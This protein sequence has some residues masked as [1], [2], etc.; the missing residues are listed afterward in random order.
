MQQHHCLY[1]GITYLMAQ[2][3][4]F[5]PAHIVRVC[6]RVCTQFKNISDVR[7]LFCLRS[8]GISISIN[9]ERERERGQLGYMYTCNDC[10]I[11]S[12]SLAL[13]ISLFVFSVFSVT[14]FGCCLGILAVSFTRNWTASFGWTVHI[15]IHVIN[16][17]S[18]IY[19]ALT[20]FICVFYAY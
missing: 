7:Q 9:V 8:F 17:I 1:S 4:G 19:C 12:C 3:W 5:S 20:K 15:S 16:L 18:F 2:S 13:L 14:F 11:P 6:V 10:A